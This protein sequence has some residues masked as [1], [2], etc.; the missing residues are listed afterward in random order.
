MDSGIVNY[1][2]DENFSYVEYKQ[3]NNILCD[4]LLELFTPVYVNLYLTGRSLFLCEKNRK[5][6]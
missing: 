1:I 3:D 4:G 5:K 2:D 6:C